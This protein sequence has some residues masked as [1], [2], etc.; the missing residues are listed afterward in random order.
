[1]GHNGAQSNS[2]VRAVLVCFLPWFSNR[3]A[4]LLVVEA[5]LPCPFREY[6]FYYSETQWRGEQLQWVHR[7]RVSAHPTEQNRNCIAIAVQETVPLITS[8]RFPINSVSYYCLITTVLSKS[9]DPK[10]ARA[11]R[12]APSRFPSP[13]VSPQ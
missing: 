3:I 11:L 7:V 5:P 13:F 1:M 4:S 10:I 2:T 8:A 6:L 12:L 9:K